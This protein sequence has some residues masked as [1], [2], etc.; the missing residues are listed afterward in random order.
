MMKS[1]AVA[2][3]ALAVFVAAPRS[4][5]AEEPWRTVHVFVALCDNATQGIVPVP[6]SIGDGNDLEKNLYWGCSDGIRSYFKRSKQWKLAAKFAKPQDGVLERIVFT[7]TASRTCLVADAYRGAEIKLCI[8]KF[9]AAA[10]GKGAATLKIEREDDE[11]IVAGINGGANLI[12]YIGHDGLMEFSLDEYPEKAREGR[13][14]TIILAC[15]SKRFFGPAIKA[16][17]AEPLVWTTH[18]MCPEAYTLHD[19]LEGWIKKESLAQIR[20]RA[21][22][23]YHK[24]QGCG[25]KGARNLLVAGW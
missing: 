16:A 5:R 24:N 1:A 19:A 4:A 11:P 18:L 14:Q 17:G 7:H 13:R 8:E 12:S 23:A 21:A 2:L 20:E 22:Q 6:A 9:V 10:A 3:A 25:I 15:Y